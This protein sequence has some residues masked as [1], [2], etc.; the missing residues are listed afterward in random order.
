MEQLLSATKATNADIFSDPAHRMSRRPPPIRS[1]EGLGF[2]ELGSSFGPPKPAVTYGKSPKSKFRPAAALYTNPRNTPPAIPEDESDDELLL[3]S[4]NSMAGDATSAPRRVARGNK[5]D[6]SDDD[7]ETVRVNGRVLAAHPDYKPSSFSAIKGLRFTKTKKNVP[8][9]TTEASP[10]SSSPTNSQE[11]LKS[12]SDDIEF[13]EDPPPPGLPSPLHRPSETSLTRRWSPSA[14][15]A[16]DRR[17]IDTKNVSTSKLSFPTANDTPRPLAKPRPRPRVVIKSA[18]PKRD[19]SPEFTPRP[20]GQKRG[21][22]LRGKTPE[23]PTNV[24]RKQTVNK[25][26]HSSSRREPQEFPMS[27]QAKENVSDGAGSGDASSSKTK[28]ISRAAAL[29]HT[30]KPIPLPSPLK[31]KPISRKPIPHGTTFPNLSP[32]SSSNDKGKA[33]AKTP[34]KD[35]TNLT[36][37]L[38]KRPGPK[39]FPMSSQMLARIDR[40][41]KSPSVC[42]L[43]STKRASSDDSGTEQGRIAKKRKDSRSKCAFSL[44]FSIMCHA[45]SLQGSRHV[46]LST[47]GS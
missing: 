36:D 24:D 42:N 17:L 27:L 46:R 30:P 8:A 29:V 22:P 19:S 35:D 47:Y 26:V 37:G 13:L 34:D 6:T 15:R 5:P 12:T 11:L 3:S 20:A 32:L 40:R 9:T 28:N 14:T 41:S 1:G 2:Q 38:G 23:R 39:P 16:A 10:P 43:Q 31:T 33:R 4:R 21:L 25:P 18:P 44:R 45:E 7:V